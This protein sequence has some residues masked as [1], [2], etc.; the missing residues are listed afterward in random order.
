MANIRDS[1]IWCGIGCGIRRG[2]DCVYISGAGKGRGAYRGLQDDSPSVAA[3]EPGHELYKKYLPHGGGSIFTFEIKGGAKTAH[4][5]STEEELLD[6][7]IKQN[8]IRLSIGIEK[9][10]DLIEA[11][12]TAFRAVR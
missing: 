4:S 1:K 12:D 7:G 5:Q 6:Q 10:E 2:G 11:L 8:T 9:V 3:G